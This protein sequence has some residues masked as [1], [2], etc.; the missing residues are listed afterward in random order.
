MA[1]T[2]PKGRPPS[3]LSPATLTEILGAALREFARHGFDGAS[4]A[5]INREL[6]VSHNLIHQR[7]GSKEALWYATVDWVFG[8]I[9]AELADDA[10]LIGLPPLEQVRRTIVRFL[11]LNAH[12]PEVLRLIT[13]EGA[14][15]SPRLAYVYEHHVEPLLGRVTAPLKELVDRGQLTRADVRS[16]HFLIAHGATAPFSLV[17]LAERFAGGDHNTKKAIHR[18]AEFVADVI[19]GGIEAHAFERG[20]PKKY[21]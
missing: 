17:P 4:V 18:H 7:F 10:D 2:K 5:A 16:L 1:S 19:I 13:V 8:E 14:I 9:A 12:R 20:E 3:A 11:E 6:N 21:R 15:D